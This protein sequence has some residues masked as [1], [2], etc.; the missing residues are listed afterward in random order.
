MSTGIRTEG[1]A[2]LC[3]RGWQELS[4]PCVRNYQ[5]ITDDLHLKEGVVER[6]KC[7]FVSLCLLCATAAILRCFSPL[8]EYMLNNNMV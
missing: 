1:V 8:D 5:V 6:K 4:P 7:C 3:L 2:R